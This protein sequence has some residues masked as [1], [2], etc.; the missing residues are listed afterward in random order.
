MH[1]GKAA[2][3][4]RRLPAQTSSTAPFDKEDLEMNEFTAHMSEDSYFA[5]LPK[6]IQETIKQTG[7]EFSSQEELRQYAEKLMDR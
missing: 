4:T 2:G 7:I 3:I 6:L 1:K 5:G